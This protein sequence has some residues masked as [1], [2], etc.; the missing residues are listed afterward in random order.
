MRFFAWII[1]LCVLVSP[2]LADN[3]P[4]WYGPGGL[5]IYDGKDFPAEWDRTRNVK[6]KV[7]IPGL[8]H[9]SPIVWGNRVF[10][11]TAVSDDPGDRFIRS[12]QRTAERVD[13]T[14]ARR[15]DGGFGQCRGRRVNGEFG[16]SACDHGRN[17]PA[18]RRALVAAAVER[19]PR[20]ELPSPD[21]CF[22]SLR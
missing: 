21:I 19:T 13:K 14:L 2:A 6:W 15:R 5:G 8:A 7:E 4:G 18:G 11:T 20:S 12:R 17:S 10:V 16:K 3:W 9:S 1:V 22:T